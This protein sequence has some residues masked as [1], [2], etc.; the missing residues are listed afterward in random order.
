[1]RRLRGTRVFP[2]AFAITW[3]AFFLLY[4]L[5]YLGLD[6]YQN[7]I[8]NAYLWLLVGILFRLPDLL[9][10]ARVLTTELS[11]LRDPQKPFESRGSG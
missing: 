3:Y 2:I 4:P 11:H 1:V 8:A 5:T 6:S 7:Y 9:A 10:P